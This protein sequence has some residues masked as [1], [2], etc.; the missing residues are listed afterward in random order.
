MSRCTVAATARRTA[1]KRLGEGVTRRRELSFGLD[2]EVVESGELR[3][4]VE[5]ADGDAH[6]SLRD[7]QVALVVK[8]FARQRLQL[9]GGDDDFLPPL[10]RGREVGA[11]AD[12]A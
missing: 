1:A 3:D 2:L 9:V 8:L 4:R 12:G 10:L 11:L 7:D 5:N 6:A